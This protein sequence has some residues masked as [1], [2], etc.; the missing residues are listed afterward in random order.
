MYKNRYRNYSRP[1]RYTLAKRKLRECITLEQSCDIELEVQSSP[2]SSSVLQEEKSD[3]L[4]VEGN[5]DNLGQFDCVPSN[6]WGR[7]EESESDSEN[8][9]N[10]VGEEQINN[11]LLDQCDNLLPDPFDNVWP[12]RFDI[13]SP[14]QS[15]NALPDQI[16]NASSDLVNW[17]LRNNITHKALTE[18]LTWFKTQPDLTNL[19]K[20]ARTLLNTPSNLQYESMG[21]GDFYYFGITTNLKKIGEMY[22]LTELFLDF[23][24]DGLPLHKSTNLSFWP[25]MCLIKNIGK[26]FCVCLFSGTKKPPL[27]LF[28]EKFV[29]ELRECLRGIEINSDIIPVHIGAFCCDTPAQAFVKNIKGRN[30]YYGCD[31]CNDRGVCRNRRMCFLNMDAPL[32]T[33]DNFLNQTCEGHHRGDSPLRELNIGLVSQFPIDYMHCV[34][35]GVMRKLLFIWRDGS[36]AYTFRKINI[37]KLNEN[38]SKMKSFWPIEFNRKP[39]SLQELERWKA[40]ELRQ[41]LLYVG[42]IVLKGVLSY[43]MY[44]NFMLL[45]YSITILLSESLNKNYNNYAKMLLVNFFKHSRALY[46]KDFCSYNTHALIHLSEDAKSYHSLNHANCFPFENYLQSLKRMLRKSNNVLQQAVHR[47]FEMQKSETQIAPAQETFKTIGRNIIIGCTTQILKKYQNCRFYNKISFDSFTLSC[48][49]GNNIIMLNSKKIIEIL[50]IVV[51]DDQKI[52]IGKECVVKKAFCDYPSNSEFH[53]L[54]EIELCA[55]DNLVEFCVEDILLKGI[56]L[57]L[58]DKLIFAPL[59]HLH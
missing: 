52:I 6:S 7:A 30:G 28:F 41:F 56:V 21:N 58:D 5:N 26:V 4:R 57:P 46:G 55:S 31:K 27:D 11:A 22:K 48:K 36:R 54:L 37:D 45:K 16:G 12:N 32:R 9:V 51:Q 50:H 20:D 15:K 33:D 8:T 38:I 39:R 25:I 43:K 49:S 34:C 24:V 40:T 23:G 2:R 44:A 42:P 29:H 13:A 19:P 1:Y 59:V 14:D 18:L 47:I 3:S 17:S 35:L 10:V 53:L